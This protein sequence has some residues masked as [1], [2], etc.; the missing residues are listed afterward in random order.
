MGDS[1]SHGV[2]SSRRTRRA[3]KG[4]QAR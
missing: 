4:A 2:D 1:S 3:I